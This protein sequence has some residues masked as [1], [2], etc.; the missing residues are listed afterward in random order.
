MLSLFNLMQIQLLHFSTQVRITAHLSSKSTGS[1][2]KMYQ[3]CVTVYFGQFTSINNG[4]RHQTCRNLSHI[5]LSLSTG[6]ER[7]DT[8]YFSCKQEK[9]KSTLKTHIYLHIFTAKGIKPMTL[10]IERSSSC[11]SF[12][13]LKK[14]GPPIERMTFFNTY[15]SLQ[16]LTS[17]HQRRDSNSPSVLYL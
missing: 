12:S 11:S 8:F 13:F 4:R 1:T 10:M 17:R 3:F 9:R 7:F 5:P 15:Q 6:G 2:Q 16:E 14:P